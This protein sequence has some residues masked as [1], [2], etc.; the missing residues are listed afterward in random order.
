[1]GAVL[2]TFSPSGIETAYFADSYNN[3]GLFPLINTTIE[4]VPALQWDDV[5]YLEGEVA[6]I[7]S[8]QLMHDRLEEALIALMSV[9]TWKRPNMVPLSIA[10]KEQELCRLVELMT[11]L[12]LAQLPGYKMTWSV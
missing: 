7:A 3:M 9:G 10:G 8:I 12:R 2:R 6:T 1:M 11:Q 4:P 5:Q